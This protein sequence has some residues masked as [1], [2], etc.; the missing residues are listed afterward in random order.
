MWIK[1]QI[2]YKRLDLEICFLLALEGHRPE[3]NFKDDF[4]GSHNKIFQ[5][6]LLSISQNY[7]AKRYDTV[8][9]RSAEGGWNAGVLWADLC[10]NYWHRSLD[11]C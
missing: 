11:F 10:H 3:D 1:T 4:I 5:I 7:R 6:F 2:A 8:P 9:L